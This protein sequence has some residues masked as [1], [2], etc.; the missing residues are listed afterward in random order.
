MAPYGKTRRELIDQAM[1]LWHLYAEP[2]RVMPLR[3]Q[4]LLAEKRRLGIAPLN[5]I[6]KCILNDYPK[7]PFFEITSEDA[8]RAKL[9]R[10]GDL[11]ILCL[12]RWID[13]VV[14]YNHAYCTLRDRIAEFTY[15]VDNYDRPKSAFGIDP[16]YARRQTRRQRAKTKYT[17]QD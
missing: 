3:Y 1:R 2:Y 17:P 11:Q 12:I 7:I 10:M 4:F 16:D 6:R 13:D 15:A 9:D 5:K 8:A 14:N